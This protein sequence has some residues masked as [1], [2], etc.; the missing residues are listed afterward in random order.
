MSTWYGTSKSG[1]AV[2]AYLD[3]A[4]LPCP[5]V[6]E[7]TVRENLASR[8]VI[9]GEEDPRLLIEPVTKLGM[10][11]LFGGGH[12][13]QKLVPL[14]AY[15]DFR[16]TVCEDRPDFADKAL[17]PLAERTV[18]CDFADISEAVTIRP[19]DSVVIM[20][21]GH[22]ADYEI[23]RQVLRTDAN[24]IGCIGSRHKIAMTRQRLI[25]DGFTD[26]E[27]D[28]VYT[29]IG[30]PILAETPEEI[31]ISVAAQMIEH[32]AKRACALHGKTVCDNITVND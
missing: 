20:T 1:T 22:R 15:V 7:A 21:R 31:G 6:S 24:Y 32:R 18:L 10:V 4:L 12:V 14:L 29:P 23:L 5:G 11:Y 8:P 28:R 30:I 17:F 2:T 26:A 9:A 25:E 27:F 19:D 16:I 3:G 13:A